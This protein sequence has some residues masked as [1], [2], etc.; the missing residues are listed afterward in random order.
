MSSLTH[1][2]DELA[3]THDRVVV[4]TRF[5]TVTGGRSKSGAVVFLGKDICCPSVF[6]L[7]P[8]R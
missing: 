5:G 2:H 1:L 6:L 8:T 4:E 7:D 3:Q